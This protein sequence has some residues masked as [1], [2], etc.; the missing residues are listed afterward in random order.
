MT[1]RIPYWPGRAIVLTLALAHR[2]GR[3]EGVVNTGYMT[4]G[5]G[6]LRLGRSRPAPGPA[7]PLPPAGLF[8]DEV[9]LDIEERRNGV[10]IGGAS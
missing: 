10:R 1:L 7:R 8:V 6:S 3:F 2:V 5:Y 9:D 4:T